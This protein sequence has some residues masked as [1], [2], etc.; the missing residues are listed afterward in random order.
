M[1]G[2]AL[3]S[4]TFQVR[5][6]LTGKSRAGLF[7]AGL[8]LRLHPRLKSPNGVFGAR[9]KSLNN[10]LRGSI[11]VLGSPSHRI[12]AAIRELLGLLRGNLPQDLAERAG[13]SLGRFAEFTARVDGGFT[14]YAFHLLANLRQVARGFSCEMDHKFVR[15]FACLFIECRSRGRDCLF[16]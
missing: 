4:V 3:H 6:E 9:F 14:G 8:E 1:V 12:A 7:H 15:R 10:L 2:I 13:G 11:E 5:S 16:H